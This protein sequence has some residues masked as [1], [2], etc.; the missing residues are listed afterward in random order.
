VI[1]KELPERA[2]DI[3]TLY[4]TTNIQDARRILEKYR[5]NW[6]IVGLTEQEGEGHCAISLGCPPY[7]ADGLAKFNDMLDLAYRHG[8]VSIYHVP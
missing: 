2:A 1:D 8:A 7:P 4:G 5:I 6:V 3:G